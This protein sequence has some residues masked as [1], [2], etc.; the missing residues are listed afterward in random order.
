MDSIPISSVLSSI[1]HSLFSLYMY[2]VPQSGVSVSGCHSQYSTPR[3]PNRGDPAARP[4][5]TVPALPPR[6]TRHSPTRTHLQNH[7]VA[8]IVAPSHRL[9]LVQIAGKHNLTATIPPQISAPDP[10]NR[11]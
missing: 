7:T 1:G 4:I 10:V 3:H 8:R 9:D 11:R 5:R 6:K 2:T